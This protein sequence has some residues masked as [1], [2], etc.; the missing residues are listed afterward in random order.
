MRL[1]SVTM[2]G[3][4]ALLRR[5]ETRGERGRICTHA[6]VYREGVTPVGIRYYHDYGA[7]QDVVPQRDRRL[8]A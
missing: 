4:L 2:H 5:Y 1:V 3:E 6:G 7:A 8:T